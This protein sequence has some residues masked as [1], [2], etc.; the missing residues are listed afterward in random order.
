MNK[1]FYIYGAGIVATSLYTAI[2]KV[3]SVLPKA[4]IVSDKMGNPDRIDGIPV[5][6]LTDIPSYDNSCKFLIA[7]PRVHYAAIGENLRNAGVDESQLVFAGDQLE[8]DLLEMYYGREKEFATI[9]EVLGK[10]KSEKTVKRVR[11]NG[12]HVF[13]AQAKCHVD[14]P[15]ESP[16]QLPE[17]VAPIQV[18]AALTDCVIAK[19]KDNMGANISHKNRNYCELTATYYMWKNNRSDYKGIC[20]YRRIF[21]I[22]DGQMDKLIMANGGVDA[23]LPYPSIHYPDIGSQHCRYVKDCD[24]NAMLQALKE[25]VPEYYDAYQDYVSRQQ[26]FYNYN[27]LIARK[28]V[29]DDYCNWLFPILERIE[30]LSTPKGNERSDRYIGYLGENLTTLYFMKNKDKLKIAHAGI[31]MLV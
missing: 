13:I 10:E 21:D 22:N 31:R 28:E 29:F 14:K 1:S 7:T 23:I 25:V 5:I 8:N 15:L 6:A 12:S 4:F 19:I 11:E 24:W 9:S 26:Y 2:K 18:G 17:F 16:I 20:H 30:E 27:M 3:Y